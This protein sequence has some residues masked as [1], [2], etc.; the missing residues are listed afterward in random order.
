MKFKHPG[1]RVVWLCGSRNPYPDGVVLYVSQFKCIMMEI[2]EGIV[3]A[4]GLASHPHAVH[5]AD[6]WMLSLVLVMV[7]VAVGSL[8][9]APLQTAA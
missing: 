1:V 9:A 8:L 2:Q 4:L 5:G 3:Q 7:E 6:R